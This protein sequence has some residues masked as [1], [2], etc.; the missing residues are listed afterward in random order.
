[1]SG[2]AVTVAI[3]THDAA[4]DLPGCLEAVGR[5]THRPLELVVVDCASSDGSPE[6]AR[7][8]APDGIPLRILELGENRGFAGGMNAA[9][10]ASTAPL[11]LTL[12]ADATLDPEFVARLVERLRRSAEHRPGAATGRISRS[13]PPARLD[14]CGMYLFWTWRHFDRGAGRTDRGQFARPARVFG[15]TGAATLWVRAAVEDAAVEAGEIFDARFHTFREDAELSMRL[16]ERGFSVLYEPAARARHRRSA[17]PG[18]RSRLSALA[19]LNSLRN[20]YLL[21]IDHQSGW[22]FLWTLPATLWRDAA[23]LAWA[24]AFER[25]SLAA[26]RWLWS[27]RRELVAHRRRVRGR[28]LRSLDRWFWIREQ[29]LAEEEP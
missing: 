3:V 20:R 6:V 23:A 14:A 18:R 1:M 21:R 15:A 17:L 9:F 10:A 5:Q 26:Y 7:R 4:S 16:Q 29:P 25:S 2:D 12:N 28:A 11:F 22:N 13:E 24:L 19:N 27:H 8:T